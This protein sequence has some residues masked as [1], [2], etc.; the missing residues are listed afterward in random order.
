M[1]AFEF[2]TDKL[3]L[4]D[5]M[6]YSDCL[7]E[8]EVERIEKYS[9][10][11]PMGYGELTTGYFLKV[12]LA[13]GFQTEFGLKL[14]IDG[15]KVVDNMNKMPEDAVLI[16]SWDE[17]GNPINQEELKEENSTNELFRKLLDFSGI[18]YP[19]LV[20][21]IH[22][23]HFL[24][25]KK[26]IIRF[27]IVQHQKDAN[28]QEIIEYRYTILELGILVEDFEKNIC[29]LDEVEAPDLYLFKED[30]KIYGRYEDMTE[31][32]ASVRPKLDKIRMGWLVCEQGSMIIVEPEQVDPDFTGSYEELAQDIEKR[33]PGK[34]IVRRSMGIE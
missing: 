29:P 5:R 28:G 27:L 33:Y 32:I 18:E 8:K 23:H 31:Y 24:P 9:Y 2:I 3:G 12:V 34:V 26:V 1:K 22:I 16:A 4:T 20:D 7:P 19:E 15:Q 11:A 30:S 25:C 14:S 21:C 6:E 13:S 17:E 10:Q